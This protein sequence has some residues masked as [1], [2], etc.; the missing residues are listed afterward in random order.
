MMRKV[1]KYSV[2]DIPAEYKDICKKQREQMIEKLAEGDEGIMEKYIQ[3]EPVDS[4]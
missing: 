2:R 3:N 1:E 4:G